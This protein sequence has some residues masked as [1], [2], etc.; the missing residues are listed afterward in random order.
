M[1]HFYK[2]FSG[3]KMVNKELQ[4]KIENRLSTSA[5]WDSRQTSRPRKTLKRMC[6]KSSFREISIPTRFGYLTVKLFGLF[7]VLKHI[8]A[9]KHIYTYYTYLM[10]NTHVHHI[11]PQPRR[12]SR[13]CQPLHW[14]RGRVWQVALQRTDRQS[15]LTLKKR[16]CGESRSQ[17]R[18]SC[19]YL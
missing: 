18:R 15:C 19:P 8:Y 11:H 6:I 12:D 17:S 14:A 13:P 10:Y 2:L 9:H 3:R 5:Q 16:E 4:L 7:S 1:V